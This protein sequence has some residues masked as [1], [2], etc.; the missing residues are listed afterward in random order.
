MILS[1]DRK[2]VFVE[3]PQTGS[4]AIARE[5][6]EN[7]GGRPVLAKHAFYSDF[8]R[9]ARPDQKDY[10]VFAGVRNPM[11]VIVSRYLKIRNDHKGTYTTPEARVANG[12]WVTDAMMERYRFVTEND[13]SFMDYF[14]RY[15]RWPYEDWATMFHD[16]FDFVYRFEDMLQGFDQALHLMGIEPV[17]PLPEVNKTTGKASWESYYDPECPRIAFVFGP[18]LEQFGY[19]YP[20]GW[21]VGRAPLSAKAAYRGIALVKNAHRRWIRRARFPVKGYS[22][23]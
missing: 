20:E 11:D 15:Y 10:F 17:R 8:L 13:A 9:H 3:L 14:V 21:N 5:L 16:R 4:T 2:Y 1:D 12:G 7:Y 22:M 23:P 6:C 18:Y 19:G